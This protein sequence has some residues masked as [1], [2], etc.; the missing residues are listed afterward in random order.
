[1]PD[2]IG[3]PARSTVKVTANNRREV[4]RPFEGILLILE[5][6]YQTLNLLNSAPTGAKIEV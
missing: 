2:R 4:R 5:E 6:L 1:M 3:G